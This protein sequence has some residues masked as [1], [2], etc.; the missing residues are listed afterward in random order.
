MQSVLRDG[1]RAV[2]M[3]GEAWMDEVG[4]IG[5]Y[6]ACEGAFQQQG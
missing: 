1:S 3:G 5:N 2:K 4:K 6:S